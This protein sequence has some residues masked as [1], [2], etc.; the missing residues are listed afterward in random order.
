MKQGGFIGGGQAGYN[1]KFQKNFIVGLETDIQG[2]SIRGSNA[3]SGL[4]YST[5]ESAFRIYEETYSATSGGQTAVHAGLHW[6]GT[7]RG[8]IGYLWTPSFLIYGT[9]GLSYGG[10]YANVNSAA[11]VQYSATGNNI[12]AGRSGYLGGQQVFGGGSYTDTL[13]GYNVGGGFELILNQNWSLKTEALYYNLGSMNI[14][15]NS[16]S[17][18]MHSTNNVNLSF[19]PPR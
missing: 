12:F 18:E 15:M 5:A 16:F 14:R 6:M 2:T 1:F 17:P 3:T 4:G 9:A 11:T 10:A 13:V 19:V 7:V 8:R